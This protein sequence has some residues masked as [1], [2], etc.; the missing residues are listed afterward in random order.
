VYLELKRRVLAFGG[1]VETYARG[2]GVLVFKAGYN[3]A[4]FFYQS[5]KQV[6][7]FEVRPEGFDI[8]EN[9][10]AQVH[11]VT[12]TRVPD[13]HGWSLNHVFDIDGGADLDAVTKLLRQSYD[14]VRRRGGRQEQ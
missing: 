14:A 7:H 10:S 4:Q 6:L 1:D 9:Q 13:R 5:R 3:F 2:Q 8:P 12:V 11:G